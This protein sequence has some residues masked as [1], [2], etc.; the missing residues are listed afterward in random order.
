[1]TVYNTSYPS[2]ANALTCTLASLANSTTAG[3]SC[4]AFDNT[5]NKYPDIA[6]EVKVKT[7]ASAP[8]GEK[9]CYIY[10]YAS[11][12][13]TNYSGSSAEAVGT[14][15]AVTFDSPTNLFGPFFLSCPAAATTYR[16]QV[17]SLVALLGFCP[18]KG[19]VVV[20]NQTGNALDS[21]GGNHSVTWSAAQPTST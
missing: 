18:Q 4:A 5:T 3:R 7:N 17:P 1:M 12:D 21:T 15:V 14:D 19:G 6:L 2:S 10:I 20:Q 13:G 8:T 9:G 11:M 16:L